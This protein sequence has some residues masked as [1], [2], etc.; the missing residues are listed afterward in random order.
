MI[1]MLLPVGWQLDVR[2][3]PNFA[4]INCADTSDRIMI[5][6]TSPV[7]GTGIFV[8]PANASMSSNRRAFLQQKEGIMRVFKGPF[9]CTIEQSK[10]LAAPLPESASDILPEAHIVGINMPVPSFSDEIPQI[11]AGAS[12]RG[13]SHITAGPGRL[14]LTGSVQDRPAEMRLVALATHRTEGVLGGGPVT[15]ND[16]PLAAVIYAPPGQLDQNDKLLITLISSVQIDPDWTRNALT[17]SRDSTKRST[18]PT[19]RIESTNRW[20]KTTPVR[21]HGRRPFAATHR[22]IA[23]RGCPA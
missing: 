12:Q 13:G 22:T 17:S 15:Y 10:A 16:L 4:T 5:S 6:S 21:P 8:I 19:P 11:V 2:P 3:G 20:P 1:K 14:R 7:K 18:V 9:N 23:A